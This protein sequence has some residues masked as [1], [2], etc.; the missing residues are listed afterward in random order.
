M[1]IAF[2]LVNVEKGKEHV[3]YRELI[4]D[5]EEVHLLFGDFNLLVR[6]EAKNKNELDQTVSDKIRTVKGVTE[7]KTLEGIKKAP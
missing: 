6:V 7:T 5:F 2:V 1:P 3:V 4:E